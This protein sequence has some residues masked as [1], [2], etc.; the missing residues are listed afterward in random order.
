MALSTTANKVILN[1]NG[2][3]TVWPYTFPIPDAASLQVT[4]TDTAGVQTLLGASQYSVTGLATTTGGNVTYPLTGSPI[5]V[6]TKLTIARIVDYTQS[7]VFTNQGGYF[8]KVTEDRFDRTMMGEQQLAE[9]IARALVVPI[10]DS[11]PTA[12]P[13]AAQRANSVLGFDALG[14][15]FAAI[16]SGSITA[17]NT[18]VVTNFFPVASAAAARAALGSG[19]PGPPPQGRLTLVTGTPVMA[20]SQSGK[21]TVFYTPYIGNVCPIWNATLGVFIP[22]TFIELSNLS[23][24]SSVGSA[25]PAAVTTSKN[26]DYFVW[27]NAGTPTLT[28]GAA[29]N[30]DTARSAT[31]ENDLNRVNGILVNKNAITNGPGANL[32]TYVG[33]GRSD[34]SSLFNWIPGGN[35]AGGTAAVLGVW[36]MY[37]RVDCRGSIGDTTDTW[38]YSSTTIRPANNSATMRVSW[39]MGQQED[40]LTATYYSVPAGATASRTGVGLDVTNAFTGRLTPGGNIVNVNYLGAGGTAQQLLGFHFI[41]AC[42]QSD[43]A[44]TTFAGDNGGTVQWSGLEY[45]GRF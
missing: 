35:A 29:W 11:N 44:A 25:G 33:T 10:S 19:D 38:S 22:T 17:V 8:P 16:L 3:T 18:W 36:N 32:G 40:Y 26:Y 21:N 37:N 28:R 41:S 5:A 6:G 31:T 14:N 34:A 23:T 9:A 42:E 12:L 24:A 27:S 2:V 45:Q 1:G 20:S 30:S 43:G 13:T 4:Y 7:T 39:V 15:P